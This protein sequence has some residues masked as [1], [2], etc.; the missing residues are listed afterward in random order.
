MKRVKE[1]MERERNGLDE[2]MVGGRVKSGL[3]QRLKAM[4]EENSGWRED[5]KRRN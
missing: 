4:K 1:V 5:K 2:F 3:R